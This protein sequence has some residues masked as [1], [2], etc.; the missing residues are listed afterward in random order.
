MGMD[1]RSS[2]LSARV[3][4]DKFIALDKNNKLITWS[5]VNG[6][7]I[8]EKKI[9]GSKADYKDFEIFGVNQGHEMYQREWF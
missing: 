9:I 5:I 3:F 8:S 7:V 6:K 1:D 2:Y 4:D